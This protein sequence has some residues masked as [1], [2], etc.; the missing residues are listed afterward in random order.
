MRRPGPAL[1]LL[2]LSTGIGE[3]LS[4]SSP[5]AEFFT[6]FGL[7]MMT[8]LYGCGAILCRELKVRWRK[9]MGS[10]LLLGV[11]YGI[12]EEGIMVASW[13]NPG[14][15]DLGVLGVFG[16]WLG[17]NWVWAVELTM[18]HAIVSIT[19]PIILVELVYSDRKFEPW[20]SGRWLKVVAIVFMVDVIGG[21]ILFGEVTKFKPNIL[22]I[23]FATFLAVIAVLMAKR[24]G[25]D[26]ARRGH[27]TLPRPRSILLLIITA[28][29]LNGA[30]F[31]VLPNLMSFVL[32]PLIVS[33]L[34][35]ILTLQT[36]RLL[37]S[38]NW[39][40]SSGVHRL[41]IAAG[42]LTPF[43]LFSPIQEIDTSRLDDASGM[44]LVGLISLLLL[45]LLYRKIRNAEKKSQ[46][47][48]EFQETA[49]S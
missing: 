20:V 27:K 29:F 12:A 8:A 45:L 16:R 33:A 18:Y 6:P 41:A 17:V 5:P 21:L 47:L 13:F 22:Q 36:V 28:A 39:L 35:F 1:V 7:T 19:V 26:W 46:T 31:I 30:I 49:V 23:G 38:Y 42:T 11:A 2:F 32:G 34:G 48:I 44:A 15:Q 10:L 37:I 24:L 25:S 40:T 4:G 43:I 14:W 9:G 3:L